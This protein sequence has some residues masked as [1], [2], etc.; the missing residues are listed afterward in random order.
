MG[1]L[2]KTPKKPSAPAM[3]K[4]IL[5]GGMSVE[6]MGTFLGA[7]MYQEVTPDGSQNTLYFVKADKVVGQLL[8][9]ADCAQNYG[10]I[11]C[12]DFTEFH[13]G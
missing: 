2:L 10:F 4:S 11:K 3:E 9:E 8:A 13:G 12:L 7:A 6:Y 5:I 1:N